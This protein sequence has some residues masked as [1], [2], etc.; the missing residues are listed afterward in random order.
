[1]NKKNQKSWEIKKIYKK[2]FKIYNKN[3]FKKR[4][5]LNK[6]KKKF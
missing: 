5:S 6:I 1:M 3:Q 4:L 2:N